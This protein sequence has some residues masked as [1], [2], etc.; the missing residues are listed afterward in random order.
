VE[1]DLN[2]LEEELLGLGS[3]SDKEKEEEEPTKEEKKQKKK[4][5]IPKAKK[6]RR[7]VNSAFG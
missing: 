6:P 1:S 2:S 5:A 4:D 3:D 7:V